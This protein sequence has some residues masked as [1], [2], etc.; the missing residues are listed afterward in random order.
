MDGDEVYSTFLTERLDA[1]E[2]RKASLEQR[3]IIVITTAG[4]LATLLLA[5]AGVV[6]SQKDYGPPASVTPLLVATAAAFLFAALLALATNL[7]LRYREIDVPTTLAM[8]QAH[9]GET[10]TSALARTTAT[11]A[12]LLRGAQRANNMK[13]WLLVAALGCEA[14][15]LVLLV[16]VVALLLGQGTLTAR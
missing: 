16:V 4:A 2:A 1:Q 6:T 14:I 9:W 10:S 5:V 3:G 15:A 12:A 7:P 13:S 8:M 11:R